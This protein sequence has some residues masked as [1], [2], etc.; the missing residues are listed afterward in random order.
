MRVGQTLHLLCHGRIA[1][2]NHS[3]YAVVGLDLAKWVDKKLLKFSARRPN[4]YGL[5]TDLAAM[6]REVKDFEPAGVVVD[7][8]SSLMGAGLAAD[9]HSMIL[10]LVD[11][12]KTWRD[13]AVHQSWARFCRDYHNPNASFFADGH[14]AIALQS[15]KQ[16]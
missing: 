11:F 9:V 8:M 1:S 16:W 10:R 6:H 12:L 14:M 5:E 4:L 3:E 7:P 15:G 13:R 2:A